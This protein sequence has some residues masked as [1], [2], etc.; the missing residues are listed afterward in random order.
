MITNQLPTPNNNLIKNPK[1]KIL[2]AK[3]IPNNNNLGN[4]PLLQLQARSPTSKLVVLEDL[5]EF[6][7]MMIQ[8]SDRSRKHRSRS[9]K[10]NSS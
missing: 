3:K 4:I 8:V 5:Q 9:Q 6:P 2:L 1:A 10:R 7:M